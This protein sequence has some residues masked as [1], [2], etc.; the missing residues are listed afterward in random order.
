M[1]IVR[2]SPTDTRREEYKY[3]NIDEFWIHVPPYKMREFYDKAVLCIYMPYKEGFGLPV[4]EAISMGVPVI[5]SNIPPIRE[6][7]GN[8][9][10]LFDDE[11]NAFGFA[12]RLLSDKK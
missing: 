10:P 3:F 6:I 5:A 4:L 7:C 9:Y 12:V 11:H 8:D 1:L 2:V